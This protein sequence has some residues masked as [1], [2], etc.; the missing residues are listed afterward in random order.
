[1]SNSMPAVIV[2]ALAFGLPHEKIPQQKSWPRILSISL[3]W[4]DAIFSD[5]WAD[6]FAKA[7]FHAEGCHWNNV[8]TKQRIAFTLSQLHCI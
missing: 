1:M 6:V 2:K 7:S 4:N 5:A 3:P 8:D